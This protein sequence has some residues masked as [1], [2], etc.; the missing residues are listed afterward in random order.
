MEEQLPT[1]E[2]VV[3][4][5]IEID[6]EILGEPP[7]RSN[8]CYIGGKFYQA[9]K[10]I[11][12][13]P[14]HEVYVE[15]FFGGGH[16][17]FQKKPSLLEIVNDIYR[18][19]Y[20][21]YTVLQNPNLFNRFIRTVWMVPQHEWKLVEYAS[22]M[23]DHIQFLY[24]FKTAEEI[25]DKVPEDVLIEVA[26]NFFMWN[27]LTIDRGAFPQSK[28]YPIM[29]IPRQ[30]VTPQKILVL[31]HMH[32]RLR[33][34]H[35]Y[36]KDYKDV[37]KHYDFP[38]ALIYMDPPYVH[39]TRNK[40]DYY[41]LEFTDEDH[42]EMVEIIAEMKAKIILSGYDNEIYSELERRGW[43][44]IS[45][46]LFAKRQRVVAPGERHEYAEEF[47]WLNYE[48]PTGSKPLLQNE[49]HFPLL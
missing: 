5:I 43:K 28:V 7:Q 19:L 10:I 27:A 48:P 18:I 45:L 24:S 49:P 22:K 31:Y 23:K 9:P 29:R 4:T 26:A 3:D 42:K 12:L 13:F 34:A 35:I 25:M 1:W 38:E 15:P 32:S 47:V 36:C 39:S 37:I 30:K 6:R 11:A 21:F 16:V 2:E 40:D 20:C 44:K 14:P 17:F 8:I 33:H 41:F 46:G